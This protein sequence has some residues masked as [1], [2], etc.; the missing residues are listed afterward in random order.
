[1][2]KVLLLIAAVAASFSVIAEDFNYAKFRQIAKS[3]NASNA[4]KYAYD[5][6]EIK[7]PAQFRYVV[8]HK[9]VN[10]KEKLTKQQ[11]DELA[12]PNF[13]EYYKGLAYVEADLLEDA[14]QLY[15]KDKSPIIA[16]GLCRKYFKNKQYNQ[17]VKLVE[18]QPIV[19]Q[20]NGIFSK[21]L[22][23]KKYETI[24]KA[25]QKLLLVQGGFNNPKFNTKLIQT[26]FRYKPAT[27][28]KQDQVKFIEK[29]AQIYPIPGTDF[30]QWKGFMG[31]IGYKYKALTGKDLFP[32]SK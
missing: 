32:E 14:V 28:T 26:M 10:L 19:L 25:G 29:L 8:K 24:Y 27:V 30:S 18:Q 20:D 11:I 17:Y 22:T 21:L 4:W 15:E 5:C 16:K 3:T 9:I 1:M 2:K 6:G 7:H 12:R 31:F 23:L 13:P